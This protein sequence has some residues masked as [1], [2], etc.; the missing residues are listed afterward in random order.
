MLAAITRLITNQKIT[1]LHSKKSN[2]K[3]TSSNQSL[4]AR[5][6]ATVNPGQSRHFRMG[7]CPDY[8]PVQHYHYIALPCSFWDEIATFHSE[9]STRLRIRF[10]LSS[11]QLNYDLLTSLITIQKSNEVPR[12]SRKIIAQKTP[13]IVKSH[14]PNQWEHVISDHG[15]IKRQHLKADQ[16]ATGKMMATLSLRNNAQR[17]SQPLEL[18]CWWIK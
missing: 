4:H 13:K 10:P 9:Y 18:L 6:I 7:I 11:S 14:A 2:S 16:S 1:Q 17:R 8:F 15:P 3:M 5:W 12:I